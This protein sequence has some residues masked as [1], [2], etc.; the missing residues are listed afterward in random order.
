MQLD[1]HAGSV[2]YGRASADD[3]PEAA[4]HL[5]KS[6]FSGRSAGVA[7]ASERYPDV[8]LVDPEVEVAD[9]HEPA[10]GLDPDGSPRHLV[11]QARVCG[12]QLAPAAGHNG[13][14]AAE[15][16]VR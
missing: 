9:G 14:E 10:V 2:R 12:E 13:A 7:G 6:Q 11:E 4:P 5:V 8:L 1:E 3:V 16:P 15:E